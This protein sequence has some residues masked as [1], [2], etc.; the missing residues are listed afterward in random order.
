M[1]EKIT[2]KKELAALEAAIK[3][4][5]EAAMQHANTEDGGTSNFD[6][7]VLGVA[8][9]KHLRE[10]TSLR[11]FKCT[12][13]LHR[14]WYFVHDIPHLGQGN[15]RTRMAEAA[16]NSLRAAGYRASVSYNID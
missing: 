6:T 14:G 3:A 10:Q 4:A 8:I 7:C 9:P 15:M 16:C 1:I 11:L 13:G 5:S 2:T 12:W